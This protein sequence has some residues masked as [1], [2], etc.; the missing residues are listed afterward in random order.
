MPP[1]SAFQVVRYGRS[2]DPPRRPF[3]AFSLLKP[4]A[5]GFRPFDPV[6]HTITVAAMMR[7]AAS[8]DAVAR[9]LGW[10]AD[11]VAGFVLGHGEVFP[12]RLMH[13]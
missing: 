5:S 2:T 1:L 7:H 3:A 10:P 12:V 4:D 6:Q 9:A 13:L 11:K 8:D